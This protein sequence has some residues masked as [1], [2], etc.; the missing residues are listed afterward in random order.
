MRSEFHAMEEIYPLLQEVIDSGG[1]F[2]LHPRGT[3]MLPLL[4][5]DVLYD[6]STAA[7]NFHSKYDLLRHLRG[8]FDEWQTFGDPASMRFLLSS[9]ETPSGRRPCTVAQ[10]LDT[11]VSAT[12]FDVADGRISAIRTLSGN[13]LATLR[14]LD[15]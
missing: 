13:V 15:S 6:S 4:R 1:E 5:E 12:V 14:P 3:S 7:T 9:V 2:R 8:R 10:H 11:L